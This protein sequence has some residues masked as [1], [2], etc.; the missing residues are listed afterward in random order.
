MYGQGGTIS[1]PAVFEMLYCMSMPAAM[2]PIVLKVLQCIRSAKIRRIMGD[3]DDGPEQNPL[4]ENEVEQNI[5]K[6]LP[7]NHFDLIINTQPIGRIYPASQARR[8][9]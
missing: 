2:I 4:V 7:K 9:W 8:N 1:E 5:L 6:L 3:M